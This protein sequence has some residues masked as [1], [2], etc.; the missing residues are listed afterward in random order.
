MDFRDFVL[1]LVCAFVLG[2]AIGI[3]RQV[4]QRMAGLRTVTLVATGACLFVS[5]SGLTGDVPRGI[6]QIAAY[7]VS[8]VGFLGGG[9]IMR[10]GGTVRGLNTAATLWCAAAVGVLCGSGYLLPAATGTAMILAA[11]ILLREIAQRLAFAPLEQIDAE[12]RFRLR[13]VC[14]DSDEVHVRALVLNMLQSLPLA[15]QALQSNDLP[16]RPGSLEVHAELLTQPKNQHKL[17]Q[18]V[19]RVS[20]EKGVSAVSWKMIADAADEV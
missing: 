20:L 16:D 6:A 10:E 3:E 5:L 11:N 19:S 14:R 1:H 7:V 17:E 15:L 18:I 4:R 13:I 12:V 9:V 8:G 2:A